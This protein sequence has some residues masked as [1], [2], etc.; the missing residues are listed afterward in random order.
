M[1]KILIY[2]HI[3]L[4]TK[5]TLNNDTEYGDYCITIIKYIEL[6]QSVV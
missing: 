3:V 4:L 6:L 1:T 2:Y 5:Y